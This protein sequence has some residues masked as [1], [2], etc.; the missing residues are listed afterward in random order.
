MR[1]IPAI[2]A[3]LAVGAAIMLA[4][5]GCVPEAEPT[6]APTSA[7]PSLDAG[8]ENLPDAVPELL[9]GGTAVQNQLYFEYV[10]E[11]YRAA[12]GI[13]TADGLVATLETAGF[14][15]AAMEVTPE[16]T[17]IGLVS[18]SVVV[19]VNVQ[20]QCLVGQVFPDHILSEIAAPLGTGR[21]LVGATHP[22]S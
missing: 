11:Q 21:C 15:K 22:I 20:G 2:S 4:L 6:S 13:G 17:S 5:S 12:N 19:S 10:L 3:A 9:P 14:E 18:D 8:E 1:T 7:P 16:Y